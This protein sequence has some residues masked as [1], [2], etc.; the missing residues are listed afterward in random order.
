MDAD[1]VMET[2]ESRRNR[3]DR[4]KCREWN[5]DELFLCLDQSK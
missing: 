2:F 3:V 5:L 4:Q 1:A